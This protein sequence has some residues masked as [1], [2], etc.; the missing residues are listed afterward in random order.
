MGSIIVIAM[1]FINIRN[2]KITLMDN[3]RGMVNYGGV[4]TL[5][6]IHI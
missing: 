2:W 4:L 3:L 5:S 1:L 6:L